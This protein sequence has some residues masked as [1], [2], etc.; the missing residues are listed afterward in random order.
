MKK[1]ALGVA[2]L[3]LCSCLYI[4]ALSVV[5]GEKLRPPTLNYIITEITSYKYYVNVNDTISDFEKIWNNSATAIPDVGGGENG[6]GGGNF[7]DD[8]PEWVLSFTS[9]L[10]QST[11]GRVFLTISTTVEFVVLSVYDTVLALLYI[12]KIMSV[13]LTGIPA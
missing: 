10:E 1:I 7:S 8:T 2:I 12:F 13:F 4:G 9:W 3:L 5:T 11:I 6:I